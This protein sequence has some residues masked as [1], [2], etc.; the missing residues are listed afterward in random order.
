M[1]GVLGA[2]SRR[3]KPTAVSSVL[4]RAVEPPGEPKG[5]LGV[6]RTR[7]LELSR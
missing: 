3:P 1:E 5:A 7:E 4:G 6:W 2:A